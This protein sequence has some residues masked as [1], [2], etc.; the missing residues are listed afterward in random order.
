MTMISSWPDLLRPAPPSRY[1]DIAL[2]FVH[3]ASFPVFVVYLAAVSF[4]PRW[5]KRRS[6]TPLQLN[7]FLVVYNVAISLVNVGCFLGFLACLLRAE[8]IYGKEF[9]KDLNRVYYVYWITK[10][11]N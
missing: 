7:G 11:R 4:L 10:V 3:S 2:S 5:W 6:A 9:D 1:A 8:S